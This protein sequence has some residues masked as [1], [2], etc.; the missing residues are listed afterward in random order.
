MTAMEASIR[1]GIEYDFTI[2][3]LRMGKLKGVKKGRQWVV[4]ANSVKRRLI[5]VADHRARQNG[6]GDS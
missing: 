4:D 1:L 5:Q 2:R 6:K 3:L